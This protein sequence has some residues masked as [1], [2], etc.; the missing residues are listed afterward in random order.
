MSNRS[1]QVSIV[2]GQEQHYTSDS[3][4]HLIAPRGSPEA[5]VGWAVCDQGLVCVLLG[6]HLFASLIRLLP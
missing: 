5:S 4:T 1:L 3:F 2:Q 6:V